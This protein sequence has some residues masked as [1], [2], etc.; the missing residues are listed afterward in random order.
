MSNDS[1]WN[2]MGNATWPIIYT[3]TKGDGY[4]RAKSVTTM[5]AFI[6]PT[7]ELIWNRSHCAYPAEMWEQP[8]TEMSDTQLIDA[9]R[10]TGDAVGRGLISS[11]DADILLDMLNAEIGRRAE[12]KSQPQGKRR[13]LRARSETAETVPAPMLTDDEVREDFEKRKKGIP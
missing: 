5:L 8:V 3:F 1:P 2:I 6:K 12:A 10:T 13:K 4:G 11:D 9:T 7:G